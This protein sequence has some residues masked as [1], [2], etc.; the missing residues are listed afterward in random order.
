MTKLNNYQLGASKFASNYFTAHPTAKEWKL[1]IYGAFALKI[2]ASAVSIFAGFSFFFNF[3]YPFVGEKTSTLVISILFLIGIE[4]ITISF[5]S[6]S[7]KFLLTKQWQPL[8]F[9]A[10]VTILM[11]A[12]S[13]VVSTN[14]IAIWRSK[15]VDQSAVITDNYNLDKKNTASYYDGRISELKN[16][17]ALLKKHTWKGRLSQKNLNEIKAYNDQIL[18]LQ[19]AKRD[20][21]ASLKSNMD[22]SLNINKTETTSE[23][24]RYY[25]FV[26]FIMFF[27][28]FTQYLIAH[29]MLKIFKENNPDALHKSQLKALQAKINQDVSDFMF[30]ATKQ[31]YSLQAKEIAVLSG[32]GLEATVTV[33]EEKV[34]SEDVVENVDEPVIEPDSPGTDPTPSGEG[35]FESVIEEVE[36][37]NYDVDDSRKEAKTHKI[38]YPDFDLDLSKIHKN[39]KACLHCGETFKINHK[40]Q[41]YCSEKCRIAYWKKNNSKDTPKEVT[42]EV[43]KAAS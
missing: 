22:Q 33:D 8:Y 43:E 2:L 18:D 7:F 13:F 34:V 25:L 20:D 31:A 4:L 19:Q 6:K 11:F 10:V 28:L 1:P 35:I 24:G 3:L 23:A 17:I 21:L 29:F 36:V 41:V 16:E 40:K 32:A 37:E 26:S 15:K 42:F 12:L 30:Q 39:E 14:G 9:T 38:H 5:I 27:Q